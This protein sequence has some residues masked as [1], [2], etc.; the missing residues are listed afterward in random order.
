MREPF[1]NKS[2]ENYHVKKRDYYDY[3]DCR[4]FY[5]PDRNSIR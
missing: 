3:T 4:I 2:Q 5:Y 1:S